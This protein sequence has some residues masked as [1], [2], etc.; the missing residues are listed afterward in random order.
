MG[1][2]VT[3]HANPDVPW[4]RVR[5]N[6]FAA[7]LRAV[8]IEHRF[9]RSQVRD[10]NGLPLLLGTTFWRTIESD[11]GDFILVDRCSFGDTEKFVS[12]VYNGHGMR[13]KHY[14]PEHIDGAR[15]QRY[16]QPLKPWRRSGRRVV[17]CGQVDT[18][19]P[20]FPSMDHWY[21]QVRAAATHFRVHPA[22]HNPTQLPE[23][24]DWRD[25]KQALTLNSSVGVQTVLDGIPT[26]T[27][28]E[29]AMAWAVS[30]HTLEAELWT[31]DRM[32]WCHW[33]AWTQWTDDEV[34][35]GV[36]W[37]YLL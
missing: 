27:M 4:Q 22:G 3:I 21:N 35:E 36:P 5:G 20:H 32:P 18:Y 31:G 16:G 33:L 34:N 15:W 10:G 19:S 26:L 8:G 37:A 28:D 23:A 25:V 24:Y 7:G 9:S 1:T 11:G 29:G 2:S 12:L 17:L 30:S 14:T 6:Y 13:G